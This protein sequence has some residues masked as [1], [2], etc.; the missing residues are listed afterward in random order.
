MT[1][2]SSDSGAFSQILIH[3]AIHD[4]RAPLSSI[5]SGIDIALEP[6]MSPED[7]ERV[8]RLC[9]DST[10]RLLRQVEALLDIERMEGA[11]LPVALAAHPLLPILDEALGTISNTLRH[12]QIT[13]ERALSPDL[14]EVLIDPD[15]TRRI[16]V[17]LLDNAVQHVGGARLIRISLNHTAPGW[18]E[19]CIDDNG[20]GVSLDSRESI[21]TLGYRAA[22]GGR[23]GYG[24]GL[25][26]CRLAAEA[27][28]GML[29]VRDA[30]NGMSGARFAL[31]LRAA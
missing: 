16:L 11:R 25:P 7:S 5:L 6:G 2:P 12:M 9:R 1:Q 27:Q 10:S 17:N 14:P 31:T 13:V 29:T 30:D 15:L 4:L 21:F 18:V 23:K 3:M 19:L 28:G 20:R 24:W 8:L 22:G 26:F